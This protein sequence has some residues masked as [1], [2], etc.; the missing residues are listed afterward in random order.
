M[1]SNNNINRRQ[2]VKAASATAAAFTVGGRWAIAAPKKPFQL[3][4]IL[5]SSMYGE[6][7]VEKIL[8]EVHKT[9]A[10]YIDIWPRRHGAQREQIEAMGA[11]AFKQ[12]LEQHKVKVGIYT[13]YKPRLVQNGRANESAA[14]FWRQHGDRQQRRQK[15]FDRSRS[16]SRVK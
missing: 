7:H 14:R 2:F 16:Q 5:A 9:G 6:I 15:E 1:N 12:L 11:D 13:C 4:Y 10:K 3:N 8:P